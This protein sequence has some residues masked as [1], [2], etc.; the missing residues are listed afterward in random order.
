[1]DIIGTLKSLVELAN[2]AQELRTRSLRKRFEVIYDPLYAQM[3]TV[4]HDYMVRLVELSNKSS[5]L[6]A[7]A[8]LHGE[9]AKVRRAH[10]PERIEVNTFLR[11]F[12]DTKTY[13]EMGLSESDYFSAI[14]LYLNSYF[15]GR[16]T[17]TWLMFVFDPS[18]DIYKARLNEYKKRCPTLK[19]DEL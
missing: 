13:C 9:L 16:S 18:C 15:I 8:E 5:G 19:S 4:H 3:N 17:F 12:R 14:D 6:Q 1:M 7:R 10:L 2:V 11:N